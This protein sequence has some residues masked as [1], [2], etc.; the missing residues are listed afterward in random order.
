MKPAIGGPAA[1]P[2]ILVIDEPSVAT[3]ALLSRV[4]TPCIE[5]PFR[6]HELLAAVEKAMGKP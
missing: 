1:H 6:V 4:G 5:E 3:F 2:R